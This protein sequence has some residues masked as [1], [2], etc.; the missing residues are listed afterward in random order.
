MPDEQDV[1]KQILK[2]KLSV[3]EERLKF[4]LSGIALFGAAIPLAISLYGRF[5]IASDIDKANERIDKA[6]TQI[7]QEVTIS[8]TQNALTAT[9]LLALDGLKDEIKLELRDDILKELREDIAAEARVAVGD[10]I[11]PA[12]QKMEDTLL[13]KLSADSLA[14]ATRFETFED[15]TDQKI[16]A[17]NTKRQAEL[18]DFEKKLV[19]EYRGLA[20]AIEE[21]E[22][23][24]VQSNSGDGNE[25][26]LDKYPN[27][28]FRFKNIADGKTIEDFRVFFVDM[29]RESNY[30]HNMTPGGVVADGGYIIRLVIIGN[31]KDDNDV[32]GFTIRKEP[33]QT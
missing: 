10:S 14:Q 29:D 7:S 25:I 31:G 13:Q 23:N 24:W 17:E 1:E 30:I 2:A 5:E 32:A 26:K 27:L 6:L 9:H 21:S 4:V 19:G 20:K 3:T 28:L 33:S 16:K 11:A 22:I 18:V 15:A 8:Q 12:K